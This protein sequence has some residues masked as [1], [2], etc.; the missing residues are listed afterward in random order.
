MSPTSRLSAGAD[1]P[2]GPDRAEVALGVGGLGWGARQSLRSSLVA[3]R[4]DRAGRCRQS[5]EAEAKVRARLAADPDVGAAHLL[6]APRS[7]SSGRT[8]LRTPSERRPS[9]SGQEALDHLDRVRPGIRRWP[10]CS[11]SAEAMP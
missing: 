3:G 4:S 6:V 1:H 9:P 5:G 2:P 11:I 7:S 8:H 10:S